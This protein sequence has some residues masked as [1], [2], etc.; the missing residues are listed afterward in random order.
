MSEDIEQAINLLRKNGYVVKKI[1][2]AM[3]VDS[4]RCEELNG[5]YECFG[6]ACSI[7]ILNQ[8]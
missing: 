8:N 6:C 5:N 2:R 7:C 3:E 1:S 4:K